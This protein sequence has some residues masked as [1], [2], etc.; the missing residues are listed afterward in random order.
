M[1]AVM[2]A[3]IHQ[4]PENTFLELCE[5]DGQDA[6]SVKRALLTSLS[7]S[8][9]TSEYLSKHLVAFTSDGA[10]AIVSGVRTCLKKDYPSII[11]WHCLNH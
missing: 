3:V 2:R 1:K 9:F 10:S 4:T 8:G 5:L 6:V 11:L 7:K